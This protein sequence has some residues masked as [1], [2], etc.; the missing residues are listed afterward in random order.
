[1]NALK[2]AQQRRELSLPADD[3]TLEDAIL[4]Q[5]DNL[6]TDA[7]QAY[8][9]FCAE[10]VEIPQDLALALILS[11]HNRAWDT[12]RGVIGQR[13]DW[14]SDSLHE[15]VYSITEQRGAFLAHEAARRQADAG[16]IA[17]EEAA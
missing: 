8:A 4:E 17:R 12:M 1:M 16:E 5:L 2:V 10:Q 3:T 13:N 11:I 9:A 15:V 14:L 6:D 7:M